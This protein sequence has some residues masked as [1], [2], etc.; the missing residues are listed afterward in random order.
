MRLRAAVL[1]AAVTGSVLT[2]VAAGGAPAGAAANPAITIRAI[3]RAGEAVPVTAS[4]HSPVTS[5]TSIDATLTSAHP[6]RV[7]RGTYNIA[8]WVFEPDGSAQT[9]FDRELV[10]TRSVTVTFDARK[11]HL[12]RFAV[13]DPTVTQNFVL[14]EPFNPVGP[15]AFD[16]FSPPTARAQYAAPGTMPP[17][18]ELSLEGDLLRPNVSLSPVR[19]VLVRVLTRVIPANLTFTVSQARLASDLVTVK[20]IDPGVAGGVSFQPI[21]AEI[22]GENPVELPAVPVGQSAIAPLHVQYYFTPGYAYESQTDSG[23]VNQTALPILGVHHYT[24]T[25]DNAT[26]GPSPQWGPFVIGNQISTMSGAYLFADPTQQLNSSFGMAVDSSQTWLYEGT[27]LIAHSA[28]GGIFVT[29][30]T[31]PHWYTVRAQ[32]SRG[33]GATL[34]KSEALSFTF[35]SQAPGGVVDNFWPRIIPS[36]LSLRNAARHGTRTAVRIYFSDLDVNLTAHGV[37]VWASAN[38]GG[39]W[40]ALPVSR[41]GPHWTVTVAN[42]GAPGFV[43]L[44][45][46]GSDANGFTATET[47]INAYAVS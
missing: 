11:G 34:W 20:A 24:Q 29:V 45:V 7:P 14:A 4:L 18:W 39:T 17:G 38:G 41:S 27:K 6:T 32:A 3:D 8:A 46:Q 1:V 21:G 16:S 33:P 28:L 23:S 30:S 47:V 42:P 13:N 25:F 2:G 26:F 15:D 31:T 43:S 35:R 37:R 12:I 10:V 5:P 9:L 36:G 19:Y 44:R 40:Q 22:P